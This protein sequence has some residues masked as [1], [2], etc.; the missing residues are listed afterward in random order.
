MVKRGMDTREIL[1]RFRTERQVLASL[2]HPN[3]ARLLD[4]GSTPE[5][6][7]YLVMEFV[8]GKPVAGPLPVGE[9]LRYGVQIAGALVAAHARASY[10]A[11]SNRATF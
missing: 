7:P 3:I 6:L 11:I 4:A 9:V 1:R 5:G 2:D 10:T 8:E